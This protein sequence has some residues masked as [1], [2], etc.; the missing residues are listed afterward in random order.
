MNDQK[1]RLSMG[2]TLLLLLVTG[3]AFGQPL[4]NPEI[5]QK[6]DDL[7]QKMTLEEKIGQMNQYSSAFDLTGPPPQ[8]GGGRAQYDQIRNGQ[9]GS[10]LNVVGAAATRQAQRLAVEN[11]RLGIPLI[12][13]LDVIHGYRTMF[14]IPLGEAAS[15]D[16]KAIEASARVAATEA[17]AAGVQWTFAP[18]VDV[19]RDA[20]WGRIMEGAGEDPYLGSQV[21]VARVHG[22]QGTDLSTADTIA[23]CVKHYAAYGFAEAGRDYNPV[24]I[25][26]ATLRDIVLPPFHA[27]A[28]AGAATFMNSFNTIA[29]VP[30]TASHLL[31]RQILKGEWKFEGFVVSDWGSIAELIPHGVAADLREAARLAVSAGSDMDMEGRAY[32]ANLAG[33]VQSGQ[34]DEKLVDDAVRRILRIKFQLGL[35][36]DPYRYCDE[37]REKSEI[38]TPEHLAVARDVAR[39]SIV[40][41]KNERSILPLS[42]SI[43]TIAVIGPLAADKDSP[44]GSWRAQAVANSAVSLLEGVRAAVG[45]DTRVLY[46]IGAPLLTGQMNFA[47]DL[48]YNTADRSGFPAALEAAAQADVVIMALGENAF[49]TG[50]GR[51]QADLGLKGLQEEL[52]QQVFARNN[53]VIV[54]LMS[55]R[56]LTIDW[57]A[58]HVPA[59][60]EAWHAGSQAGHAIADV[61]F[62]DYNPSG[63]LPATFPRAVGQEPLYYNHLSTGRPGPLPS[64]FW[65]HYTDLANTPLFPFGYGLSFTTFGYSEIRLSS[66]EIPM[67]GELKVSVT[68]TNTGQ[69]AGTEVVQLYI[70][71][72]VASRSR[73]VKELKGFQLVSLEPGASRQVTFSLKSA[74]LAFYTLDR[75]WAAEPGAFNVYVGTNSDDVR[76]ARFTLK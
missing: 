8:G 75:K 15:W 47:T 42:R 53:N 52:L 32:I 30:S 46:Q 40:L 72:L 33:L 18:M 54:V 27:A 61:L 6:I 21:A 36:D 76:E 69:R 29:G 1:C 56:P 9:V 14:P 70:R 5:E 22:F 34:V 17:A 37:A 25:S 51:S 55:G 48:T 44:L 23:A 35:F 41:L 16:L 60:V 39:K 12:F 73:P 59:I 74:D 50:E 7:L 49:Q 66:P 10:L 19:C 2:L 26:E 4:V 3:G 64:V 58:E 67:D 43:G 20:R 11:S 38:L 45:A 31:Q 71:D 57:M 24:D 28:D 62:G 65:S 68:V 13:G 63:K